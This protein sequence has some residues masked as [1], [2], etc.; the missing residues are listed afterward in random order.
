MAT[1]ARG[2][3]QAG[4]TNF[5]SNTTAL[6]AEVN[7]D[8]NTLYDAWNNHDAGTSKHTIVSV[9]NATSTVLVVNNSNGTNDIVDFK[10][11]GT[12]TFKIADGGNI[13]ATGT[14][15]V[16]DGTQSAPGYAFSSAGNDDNGMYL[17]SNNVVAI[18]AGGTNRFEISTTGITAALPIAMSSQ[19]IT[20]LAAG[21][22]NGDAVRFEQISG[23]R[24]LS[25]HVD[26]TETQ[27]ATTSSSFT[28]TA[29]SIAVTPVSSSSKFLLMFSGGIDSSDT[30][31]SCDIM[32][33][34]SGSAL[35]GE[36][37]AETHNVTTRQSVGAVYLDSPA[38]ASPI[39]Y[40]VQ[41]RSNGGDSVRFATS[42]VSSFVIL[43]IG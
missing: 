14:I 13:T 21:S 11:N 36:A 20:G 32:L 16:G 43:E 6:A 42:G 31:S 18:S 41:F 4:G 24:V 39:T 30:A 2:S 15:K 27:E 34:R 38:T 17:A 40:T 35:A 28:N 12:S 1:V 37:F 19:K 23:L 22:A 33:A 29:L 3:K 9:E 10:D 8:F 26:T 25:S 7:T 5:T